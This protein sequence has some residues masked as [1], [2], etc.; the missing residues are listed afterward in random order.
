MFVFNT[1]IGLFLSI[2]FIAS[3]SSNYLTENLGT[4]GNNPRT[5]SGYLSTPKGAGPFPAVVLLH[6]CGGLRTHVTEDWPNYLTGLGYVV[7]SVDSYSSCREMR[8]TPY[9][10]QQTKDAFG[11]LELLAK[12]PSV[13][14]ARVGVMGFSAGGHAVNE[15]LVDEWEKNRMESISRLQSLYTVVAEALSGTIKTASHC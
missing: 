5:I 8:G 3:C 4:T 11:A 10:Y 14:G 7:F 1:R 12:K 9:M 2:L 6:T 13:D 15:Y